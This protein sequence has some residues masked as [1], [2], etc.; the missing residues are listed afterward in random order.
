MPANGTGGIN[1]MRMAAREVFSS[2]GAIVRQNS[3]G[4]KYRT[5]YICYYYFKFLTFLYMA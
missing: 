4:L 2:H 1:T 3:F 5:Q